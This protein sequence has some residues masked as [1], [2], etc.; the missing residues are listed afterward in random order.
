MILFQEDFDRYP[1][2]I[3]DTNCANQSF[4]RYSALLKHMGVKNHLWPLV[5]LNGDLRGIDPFE[6][7]LSQNDIMM[8]TVEFK[9]NP[10]AYFRMVSR[11]PSGT[12][13]HPIRFRANRGNMAL[14]WL[15][16]NHITT[17]LVQIRQ[18]GK[19]FSVDTL[20][21]YLMNVG[22][23]GSKI[24]LLTKDDSLRSR[25]LERLKEIESSLPYYLRLRGK[26]DIG[27]TEELTVN[28]LNNRYRAFLPNKS[29]KMALNVGR[30]FTSPIMQVD[31]MAFIFN[32]SISLPATLA[33]YI[34]ARDIAASKGEPYG[35]IFTTTAGKKD[36]VD[37]KYA[38][39][40]R[41]T[42][43]IWQESFFDCKDQAELELIIKKNTPK[44]E[45]V[46][47]AGC[48]VN[49][50]FNHR[51]LGYTDEW[52]KD[53]IA[54]T[55]ATGDDLDRDFF[56][57]WTSGS[58]LSPLTVAL[59]ETIRASEKDIVYSE[60][61]RPNCYITR[62]YIP[63]NAIQSRVGNE[64]T[65]LSIDS[66]DAAGGDDIAVT[67]RSV[68]TGEVL[69]AG[70]YNETNLLVFC[71]WLVNWFVK[72]TKVT[73]I[74]ERRSTGAMI[75]DYLLLMLPNKGIDPFRRIYNKVVQEADEYPDRYKEICKPLYAL[76]TELFVK[77]KKAF[78]FATSATGLTSRSELYSSGLNNAAKLTGHKVNDK[79]LIDQVLGL[80]IKNGRVDHADGEHDDMCFIGATLVRT[81]DGNRPIKD[82]KIGDLVLTREGYKPIVKLFCSEKEVVTKY[83][84]TGTPNHPFITPN[85][86]VQ[87]K[88]LRPDTKVYKWNE[89][90]SIIEEKT[91]T[92]ILSQIE[93]IS[94]IISIDT[95]SGKVRQLPFI[96]K[97]MKI[98]TAPFQKA[99]TSIIKMEMCQ[100]TLLKIWSVLVWLNIVKIIR[101]V[102]NLEKN[103]ERMAKLPIISESG[104]KK[105]PSWLWLPLKNGVKNLQGFLIGGKKIL[106]WQKRSMQK[107]VEKAWRQEERKEIVYNIMVADCH[108]Y[109]VNDILV[110]NCISWLLSYWLMSQGKNLQHYGINT[111]D[112]LLDNIVN[113]EVN[114]P[115]N[116]Y[117]RAYQEHIRNGIEAI[118]E[119]IKKERDDFIA[120][121]LEGTLRH[122]VSQLSTEE[123]QL[124]SIDGLINEIKEQRRSGLRSRGVGYSYR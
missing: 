10:W 89:K 5:L 108:E 109:F 43:A 18:T 20:M 1:K 104:E 30:G 121:K 32:L 69:A 120:A 91:I 118:T 6:P 12:P 119:A 52:L 4:V 56:N 27:N 36:D 107:Q 76:S 122:L 94:G 93:P 25:N 110:H 55:G 112:I 74:I 38:N 11:D 44:M 92:D 82:L 9:L 90:Q 37:G 26:G 50:T 113:Q 84:I 65:I 102:M 106:S 2:S 87:F 58:Q 33:G 47:D 7:G 88:D 42:S 100:I 95:I 24:N 123:R 105:I 111:R 78:G 23:S 115:T 86:E 99:F 35:L 64:S 51:Q 53:A 16:F 59:A 83:G 66:S 21:T 98:I 46:S 67:L 28:V 96:G 101:S 48:R 75:I 117:D 70:N 68:K 14:Y 8:L 34:T 116:V 97:F 77:Y 80:V 81:I 31:E 29:P 85:G 54:V 40:I 19:S 60:I 62:W 41:T 3:I 15:F 61:S 103:I 124:V 73:L 71:E 17:L 72:F 13:E 45:G 57:V 22:T 63:E 114:S 49:C 79:T 39:M